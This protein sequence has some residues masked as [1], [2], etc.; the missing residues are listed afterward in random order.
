MLGSSA[1][2][3]AV[4]S[5][6]NDTMH[7]T[8]SKGVCA[9]MLCIPNAEVVPL[10]WL[11]QLHVQCGV[12][13]R[14]VC[15][16]SGPMHSPWCT[17]RSTMST[18]CTAPCASRYFA[19]YARSLMMQK[20]EPWAGKAWCVPPAVLHASPYL[21]ASCAVSRVPA[22]SDLVRWTNRGERVTSPNPIL[23]SNS[24]GKSDDAFECKR[25]SIADA[26]YHSILGE[27]AEH[28]IT[29]LCRLDTTGALCYSIILM[30]H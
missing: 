26:H 7:T 13:C 27:L 1:Q 28:A 14:H 16:L 10:L 15:R 22:T 5:P 29:S 21:S 18:R 2:Q 20:P 25:P 23:S 24:R 9:V 4:P 30:W 3:T 6:A 11:M 19:V 17:S 12:C 8:F